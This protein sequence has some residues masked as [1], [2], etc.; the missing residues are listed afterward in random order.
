MLTQRLGSSNQ[1][2]EI[3]TNKLINS[4]NSNKGSCD[5]IWFATLY[6]FPNIE[7]HKILAKRLK[8]IAAMYRDN[9]IRVSLQLSNS[10]GHGEYMSRTDCSGLVYDGSPVQNIVGHDGTVARYCFCWNDDVLRDYVKEELEAYVG[11]IHP[12]TLWLDDDTRV[13]HHAPAVYTCFCPH[14]ISMFNER[15]GH[16][17]TREELVRAIN[18]DKKIRQEHIDFNRDTFAEYISFISR[19]VHN[20]DPNCRI[21]L[22]TYYKKSEYAGH[23]LSYIF[24]AIYNETKIRPASRP[25]GG[26]YDDHNPENF[27]IKGEDIQYQNYLLPD[28]VKEIRPEIEN[29]PFVAYGKSAAGTAFESS[30]YFAAGSTDMSY[31]MVMR[32]EEDFDFYDNE[33]KTFS[34]HR[35]YWEKLSYVNKRSHQAGFPV[36]IP[37]KAYLRDN[38]EDFDYANDFF[39]S[40][41]PLRY[42]NIPLA[43]SEPNGNAIFVHSNILELMSDE[44]IDEL[45]KQPVITDSKS[46]HIIYSRKLDSF[47]DSSEIDIG[48]RCEKVS[49]CELNNRFAGEKWSGTFWRDKD[50]ELI[51]KTKDYLSLGNYTHASPQGDVVE[52]SISGGVFTTKYGKKWA[53]YGYELWTRMVSSKQRDRFISIAE[54]ISEKK[55]VAK[56]ENPIQMIVLP[57]A[58]ENEEIVS[59][60][61]TNLTVGDSGELKLFVENPASKMALFMSQYQES[62]IV[63]VLCDENGNKYVTIPN[64]K[65]WSVGTVFFE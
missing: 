59:V 27:I 16:N 18:D 46:A 4:I 15:Y 51:P 43:F 26:M 28:Y 44:E 62:V 30:Y 54:Y 61:L 10:L 12:H 25:G 17:F 45:L 13:S 32:E 19:A 14:C 47:A 2:D 38:K 48:S 42:F 9:D 35:K 55:C 23:G 53:F 8:K 34:S 37:K 24:D 39:D 60:S 65:P 58:N 57:R 41:R 40:Y 29:I 20:V 5:E 64:I 56:L 50:Y 31:S 6:G 33:L 11:E 49:D 7:K 1:K 3:F 63:D 21:G 22:Q 52:E 36:A